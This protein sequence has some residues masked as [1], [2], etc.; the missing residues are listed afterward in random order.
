MPDK[1]RRQMKIGKPWVKEWWY[2][3]SHIYMDDPVDLFEEL[4]L[5]RSKLI[6]EE[7]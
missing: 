4:D 1:L 5:K 7:F 2:A 3:L 6:L